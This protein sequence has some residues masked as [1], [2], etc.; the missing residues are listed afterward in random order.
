MLGI[1]K[2]HRKID[3]ARAQL[4][5]SIS[6]FFEGDYYSAAT[7]AGASE[8]ILGKFIEKTGAENEL[9]SLVRATKAVGKFFGE[10]YTV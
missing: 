5:R 4:E 10:E 3:V 8:E 7:L 6:L 9:K 2:I 1:M